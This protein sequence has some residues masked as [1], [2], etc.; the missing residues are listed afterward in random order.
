MKKK[1]IDKKE[2]WLSN[3]TMSKLKLDLINDDDK[4]QMRPDGTDY[5]LVEEYAEKMAKGV[6]FPPVVVAKREDGYFVLDGFHRIRAAKKNNTEEIDAQIIEGLTI[7]NCILFATTSNMDH[8]KAISNKEKSINCKKLLSVYFND[9][10]ENYNFN[11]QAFADNFGFGKS[12]VYK[13]AEQ[14]KKDLEVKRKIAFFDLYSSGKSL[15]AI[16]EQCGFSRKKAGDF[17]NNAKKSVALIEEF[18]YLLSELKN[19]CESI[20]DYELDIMNK[21]NLPMHSGLDTK[22]YSVGIPFGHNWNWEDDECAITISYAK[23]VNLGLSN[24]SKYPFSVDVEEMTEYEKV[25]EIL[26]SSPL[27]NEATE[28]HNR[29]CA[30]HN[31]HIIYPASSIDGDY[32]LAHLAARH[33]DEEY[34]EVYEY[35]VT[36]AFGGPNKRMELI[37]SGRVYGC[38]VTQQ[39]AW[40]VP[41]DKLI[42]TKKVD[43]PFSDAYTMSPLKPNT[44]TKIEG[45]PKVTELV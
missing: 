1:L 20:I 10:V 38:P 39:R 28:L 21:I 34:A 41:E 26:Y 2:E 16:G 9:H 23:A 12:M 14:Y 43:N 17:I 31:K 18:K 40:G 4:N 32:F 45:A 25:T 24:P 33:F 42:K 5:T 11:A 27:Y 3:S 22:V 7:D 37:A 29:C 15:T 44:T 13:N 36:K 35:W 19:T 6:K 30:F 8:G